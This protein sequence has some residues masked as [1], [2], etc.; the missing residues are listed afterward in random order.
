[1]RWFRGCTAAAVRATVAIVAT[2]IAAT[3]IASAAPV[4]A[5]PEPHDPAEIDASLQRAVEILNFY[6]EGTGLP[7][8]D[9]DLGLS[10]AA[11]EHSCWMAENDTLDHFREGASTGAA[12]EMSN[13]AV[14]RTPLY[15]DERFVE[16]WLTG[17]YH[18]VSMLRWGLRTIGYATCLAPDGQWRKAAT[19]DVVNGYQR[20]RTQAPVMFPPPERTTDLY[21]FL[22]ERPNP[23]E[24]CGWER[25]GLPVF[26]MLPEPPTA[27]T[28][29][30][31]RGPDGEPV[32]ICIVTA[33]DDVTDG[34]PI[35]QFDNA[36]LLIPAEPL[37]EGRWEAEI[38]SG[39]RQVAW[40]FWVGEERH[41]GPPP[42]PRPVTA[43]MPATAP[44]G[45]PGRLLTTEVRRTLD[46]RVPLRPP[47]LPADVEFRVPI[48]T[49]PPGATAVSLTLTA[50][51]HGERGWAAVYPCAAGWTGTS[52]LNFVPGVVAA[53]S[54]IVPLVPADLEAA[55][56]AGGENLDLCGRVS[57]PTDLIVDVSGWFVRDG[58]AGFLADA[59]RLLDTRKQ[60]IPNRVPAGTTLTVDVAEPGATAVAL[61]VTA[62][63]T[64]T[65]GYVT[66][67]PCDRPRTE[68]SVSQPAVGMERATATIV[69]V[70]ADGTVC[71]YTSAH[72]H[73]IVDR[74]GIFTA[75]DGDPEG[76]AFVPAAAGPGGRHPQR[77]APVVR[78]R[79]S[80]ARHRRRRA[81][82]RLDDG[83]VPGGRDGA[84][85]ERH[86]G[87]RRA[88]RLGGDVGLRLL[89]GP[90]QPELRAR[91]PGG[92]EPRDR[93]RR[94][95]PFV[96][97][98]GRVLAPA[99]RR[100]RRVRRVTREHGTGGPGDRHGIGTRSTG[101]RHGIDTGS[102][103]APRRCMYAAP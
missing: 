37:V 50:A 24:N 19:M 103:R 57:D 61:N 43:A 90:V 75:G 54:A 96:R 60:G 77:P 30:S 7:P 4:T 48:G 66:V 99:R 69:P 65:D 9:A 18:S 33:R 52:T 72:T 25:A 42:P 6:R 80:G 76:A 73:L 26:A 55:E 2:A 13:I 36:V 41:P 59:G 1:M 32:E 15:S 95:R 31:L 93:R 3:T 28:T 92:P 98:G 47:Q 58:G 56:A 70:A 39:R 62:T 35:L 8:V 88:R 40:G 21:R 94:R 86:L 46:T 5:A 23:L 16:L 22:T 100:R 67:W 82:G 12:G 44:L 83:R 11:R 74:Q 89:R 84:R 81:P 91:A 63:I 53:N 71:V 10:L 20:G 97:A 29:G 87:Q 101:D 102:T 85:A 64:D 79:P 14:G 45:E 17:P 38:D 27:A 51:G 49:P 78:R 68:T 34:R